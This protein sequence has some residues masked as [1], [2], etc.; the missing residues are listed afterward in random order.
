MT[1][2]RIGLSLFEDDLELVR[3]ADE[4]GYG[5]VWTSE[6]QGRTAFGKLERWATA[7]SDIRLAT[8]IVNVYSRSPATLAQAIAT[9]DAHSDGRAILGLGVAHPGVISEFHGMDFDRPLPRMREYIELVRRY[10]AGT[11]D[12]FEGTFFTPDRTTFWDSFTPERSEIPIYNAAIGPKNI[13]LTGELADGWY[14][15]L[16]P[17]ERLEKAMKW[18]AEGAREGGR[19]ISD[20]DVVMN[21]PTVVG[22]DPVSARRAVAEY[23][24]TYYRGEIPGFYDRVVREAGFE[25]EIDA[26]QEAESFTEAADRVSNELV[27]LIAIVGT[28]TE[29][30][31]KVA[32]IREAG[33]DLPVV[34]PP[35]GIGRNRMIQTIEAFAPG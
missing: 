9:L 12:G 32:A 17:L 28:P 35:T 25:E 8:G 7:T 20:I 21:L 11:A 15:N 34:R 22:E 23:V 24:A 29:A 6:G 14:P 13:R 31:E 26:I 33:V 1:T 18:L 19:S 16:F 10:L 27:D 5:S 3:K 4:L 2:D 30:R